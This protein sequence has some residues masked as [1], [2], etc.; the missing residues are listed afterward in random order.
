MIVSIHQPNYFPWIGY[1]YKILM[2][3]KFI[4][5]NDVQFTK[6]DYIN[7][8]QIFSPQNQTQWLTIPISVKIGTSIDQ[9]NINH[10]WQGK[11]L[12]TIKQIYGKCM[13]FNDIFH[14]IENIL[15]DKELNLSLLNIKLIQ[16]I[17]HRFGANT[18]VYLSSQLGAKDLFADD[19]LIQLMKMVKGTEY[20]SGKGGFN[21]QSIEK[22]EKQNIR[23]LS[24]KIKSDF[25]YTTKFHNVVGLS[26]LDYIFNE[27]FNKDKLMQFGEIIK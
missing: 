23:V 22:F 2:S 5:L 1:F 10:Q 14:D 21:Y 18:E 16:Y 4:F 9:L 3:N 19:R 20:L 8:V 24:Y 13:Y 17:L 15:L 26:I 6:G 12:K 25:V 11:H 27:G 7:R